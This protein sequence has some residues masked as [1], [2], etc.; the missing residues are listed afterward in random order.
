MKKFDC[1]NNENKVALIVGG[2][3]GIGYHTSIKLLEKG[4]CVYNLSRGKSECENI[5]NLCADVEKDAELNAAI[6]NLRQKAGRLDLLV[7]SA[8]YS[9]AAP[10]E[11]VKLKDVY[12]LF[13]VNYFGALKT[14]KK[15]LPLMRAAGGGRI[16]FISSMGGVMPIAFDSFYSS[17]KAALDMLARGL[18]MEVNPFGIYVT[19][20][21]P[22]GVATRF[23]FKRNIY[24]ESE[25]G[26]YASALRAATVS[27]E[28]TEQ[29][30][31]DPMAVA[32]EI[33]SIAQ[34]KNPPVTAAIG[35]KNK[36][37]KLAQ[38]VLPEKFCDSINK[39]MYES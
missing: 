3:T 29:G 39:N 4:Y 6:E 13:E 26:E 18:N 19:S 15:S 2:S 10:V 38:K 17:S 8:G 32:D 14:V 37:F 27:L 12:R 21:Q 9:M 25:C 30:G 35:L 20:V 31:M 28:Q 22:G 36:T 33:V 5:V 23:T 34:S 16:I 24:P 7:Y 1:D 11:H